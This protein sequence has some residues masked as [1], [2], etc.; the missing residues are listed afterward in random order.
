MMREGCALS[1]LCIRAPI[2]PL[3]ELPRYACPPSRTHRPFLRKLTAP[4][5]SACPRSS[6]SALRSARFIEGGFQPPALTRL[7]RL[8]S[9]PYGAVELCT[10]P[11]EPQGGLLSRRRADARRSHISRGPSQARDGPL[12][13]G[14]P[15]L[16]PRLRWTH[17]RFHRVFLFVYPLSHARPIFGVPIEA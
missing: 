4:G 6:W 14:P 9:L 1:R 16:V 15:C 8:C 3:H 2:D 12:F 13:A 7:A 11:P 5:A 10:H 17:P